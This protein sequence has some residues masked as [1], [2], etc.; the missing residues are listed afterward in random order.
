[1]ADSDQQISL[2]PDRSQSPSLLATVASDSYTLL[3]LVALFVLLVSLAVLVGFWIGHYGLGSKPVNDDGSSLVS[4]D[5]H[6]KPAEPSQ[7]AP[8]VI[9][10]EGDTVVFSPSD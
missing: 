7:D 9:L 5:A 1:M 3:L 6:S 8:G 4:L 10:A 2:P